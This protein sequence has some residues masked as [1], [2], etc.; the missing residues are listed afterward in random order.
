MSRLDAHGLCDQSAQCVEIDDA[1]EL[2]PISG[3]SGGQQYWILKIDSRDGD[4]QRGWSH[5]YRV[6]PTRD[7]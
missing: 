1:R 6:P 3:G 2:T 7:S 4:C 5:R